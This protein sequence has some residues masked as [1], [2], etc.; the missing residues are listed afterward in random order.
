ME[1]PI[2]IPSNAVVKV[3]YLGFALFFSSTLTARDKVSSSPIL[4]LLL[5]LPH[6]HQPLGQRRWWPNNITNITI[7]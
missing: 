3:A 1:N 6:R 2:D 5:A 7:S 4:R